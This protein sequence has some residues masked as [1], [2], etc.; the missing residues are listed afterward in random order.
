MRG[1]VI[2]SKRGFWNDPAALALSGVEGRV[3]LHIDP[4]RRF[5]RGM[6]TQAILLIVHRRV[7]I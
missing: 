6:T 2:L 4:I 3:A 7:R 1:E 5:C